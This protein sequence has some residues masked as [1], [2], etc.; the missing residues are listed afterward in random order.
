M[1]AIHRPQF[2]DNLVRRLLDDQ[3]P[4]WSD[5]P[6]DRVE[7][8]GSDHAIYR[9]G[10]VLSVRVPLH[11]G[12]RDEAR[13]NAYW[14]PKLAP[15]LPLPIPAPVAVGESDFGYP[16]PWL[17]CR[18][19]DGTVATAAE[20][21]DSVETALELAGFLK[22]LQSIDLEIPDEWRDQLTRQPLSA[23]DAE[24]RAA[25]DKVGSSFD[26]A[27]L[28][29]IW[30]DALAAEPGRP[31]WVHGDFHSGNL[32]AHNGRVTTILDFGSFGF[33]DPAADLGI[34]YSLM[35][36]KVRK[37]FREEVDMDEASWIRGR[38]MAISGAV[39]AHAAYASTQPHIAALTTHQ[40]S[41]ALFG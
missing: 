33:G 40:I 36:P 2:D 31:R 5:L 25:I 11:S 38:G 41:Q 7:P 19:L 15:L 37:R 35:S 17:V 18:W 24:T 22:A 8:A 9:L 32:L 27:A 26:P 13:R 16:W 29:E 10:P 39:I 1:V 14:L 23:R 34:A 20:F 3:F 30:E 28:L 12:A 21:A 4:E 6:L